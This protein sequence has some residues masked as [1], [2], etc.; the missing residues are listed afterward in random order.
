[1][2]SSRRGTD[3]AN[4][5]LFSHDSLLRVRTKKRRVLQFEPLEERALMSTYNI[6]PGQPYTTLGSFPW[7]SL[8]P[9]DTVDIHWQPTPYYEK[10]LISESGTAS[11]PINIV[12]VPGPS[13]QQP[14]IDGDN[15]TTNSQFQYFYTPMEG[16]SLLLVARSNQPTLWLPAE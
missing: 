6:G 7:S 9:G 14:I 10:L 15:A 3:R 1:M 13:G 2:Q 4:T 5:R 11:A 12:G 8:G 16:N